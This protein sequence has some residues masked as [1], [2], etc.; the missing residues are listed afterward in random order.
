MRRTYDFKG[1]V[2]TSILPHLQRAVRHESVTVMMCN[3]W[4]ELPSSRTSNTTIAPGYMNTVLRLY[5]FGFKHEIQFVAKERC[6][7]TA[8][9]SLSLQHINISHNGR[10]HTISICFTQ[11]QYAFFL[12]IYIHYKYL[13]S[14]CVCVCVYLRASMFC[15]YVSTNATPVFAKVEII[16]PF[17]FTTKQFIK[18]LIYGSI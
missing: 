17:L 18:C 14:M 2:H 5:V 12:R 8:F 11:Y 9:R 10:G 13:L 4:A 3:D 7:T 1:N 6:L 15:K 16:K